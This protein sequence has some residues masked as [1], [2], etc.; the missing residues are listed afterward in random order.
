MK[1]AWVS[2]KSGHCSH[3]LVIFAVAIV[4]SLAV[5]NSA[6]AQCS[7]NLQCHN[8]NNVCTCDRCVSTVCQHNFTIY[9]NTNCD[10][11]SLPNVD[12]ILCTLSGFSNFANCPNAD[13]KPNCTGNNIIN[14]DDILA[15][16]NAFS[17]QDPC[18]CAT[19]IPC[20]IAADC[21]D[22]VFCN[23]A[24][25]C[26]GGFC[27]PGA[28]PCPGQG[29]SE[30]GDVCTGVGNAVISCQLESTTAARGSVVRLD[31]FVESV[32]S[33][34]AYEV[35]IVITKLS[36]PGTLEA[37]CSDGVVIDSD[38]PNFIFAGQSP[39][40]I[41]LDCNNDRAAA[42]L[43]NGSASTTPAKYL[44]EF[45]LSVS[46]TSSSCTTYQIAIEPSP[47]SQL[48]G[49]GG[50]TIGFIPGSACTLQI[51][52]NSGIDCNNNGTPD[53]CE[54]DCQPNGVADECDLTLGTSDDCNNN[55]IPDECEV[56]CQNNGIPDEC[57]ITSMTSD[58]CNNNDIPDECE[59]P[60]CQQ[61]DIPD[62]CD[63]AGPSTDCNNNLIP[64]ECD[65]ANGIGSD[66][67]PNGVFDLCDIQNATSQDFN[68]N[69]IP[70]ECD[71]FCAAGCNDNNVCTCDRCLNGLCS[72]TNRKYGDANCSG[73]IVNI[74][75]ILCTL[76]GFANLNDCRN[77][78]VAPPCMG[79]GVINLDD[80]LR[81]LGAFGGENLCGCN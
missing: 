5:S 12:D 17:G 33:L 81:V 8:D 26:T 21:D 41:A 78:D 69:G 67:Q 40:F 20:G 56:D 43:L 28:N 42:A 9:G 64:D 27:Q 46:L 15:V 19:G 11:A 44:A 31:A 49:P 4:S 74:D 72:H 65:L 71:A 25:V 2:R 35:A 45:Q 61:N 7:T 32:T 57:D 30:A 22:G 75:D 66:C 23:G 73:G 53:E 13:L 39:V 6:V 47:G 34:A 10:T 38:R 29:C 51:T 3:C 80:I 16:L 77:A 62:D 1:N 70:D 37:E 14:I 55:D 50:S 60:D 58:D 48:R 54:T 59:S 79:N 36:G 63:I 68:S 52:G 18:A 24:E 76:A